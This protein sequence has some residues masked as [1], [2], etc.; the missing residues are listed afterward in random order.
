V[1]RLPPLNALKAFAV[2]AREGSFTHAG[3]ALHVT[4]G[5]ISR[6]V[7]QLE[8]AL[9]VPL[10]IRVH[11]AVELTPAGRELAETLQRLF[12]EM[13][14]AVQRA[15]G[16]HRPQTLTVNVPPTFATRW[17][18]PRLSDFRARFPHI[19]LHITTD[20][21]GTL[22]EARALDCL[23]VFSQEPWPRTR[24]EPVMKERHVMVSSPALW[25]AGK[26]PA[27]SGATLL[28]VLD[29]GERLP[30]WEQW[31]AQH[32]PHTLDARPG[33]TFSTLDQAINA[34]IAG[35]GVVIV[36]EA[37]VVRE[38]QSGQ[39]KRHNPLTVDGPFAYWLVLPGSQ[40]SAPA[41]VQDFKGWLMESASVGQT[42][43][44]PGRPKPG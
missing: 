22:R 3:E 31:I 40:A 28:H 9:G 15:S 41:R 27:L 35:A 33:L 7:K 30:V 14:V 43:P 11:Q 39:L 20:R 12:G 8:T 24:C 44:L 18:A 13:E 17:L 29:G 4:Q 37:M 1:K 25:R 16:Q 23:V 26:P 36:D 21:I 34:A 32:G 2:A 6:Q 38:L 10:F 5:A 19:D 42:N